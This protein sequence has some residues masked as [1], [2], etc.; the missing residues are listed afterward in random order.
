M[1]KSDPSMAV[2]RE[3]A[4]RPDDEKFLTITS[5]KEK[6]KADRAN[7]VQGLVGTHDLK[8]LPKG[9]EIVLKA[10][11]TEMVLNNWAASQLAALSGIPLAMAARQPAALAAQNFAWGLQARE[12]DKVQLLLTKQAKRAHAPW[13]ARAMTGPTYGRIWDDEVLEAMEEQFGD[14]VTGIWR[15][16]GIRGKALKDNTLQTTT[17]FYG[18]KGPFVFLADE[19]NRIEVK[20][21]RDGKPGT[22]ARG[23]YI[24]NSQVGAGKLRIGLYLYDFLC[25]NRIIWGMEQ[26]EEIAI[27]HSSGAPSRWLMEAMP[28]IKSF[29]AASA[30]PVEAQIKAAQTHQLG[31]GDQVMDFLN[32]RFMKSQTINMMAV[33]VEEEGRPVATRWDAVTA[34]T[35]YA[36]SI[37]WQDERFAIERKAGEMLAA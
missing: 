19:A 29:A 28:Q 23:F 12:A 3:W 6:A 25:E 32:R 22:L 20:A 18:Q 10:D 5:A 27:R 17:I 33:H 9:D 35:A 11:D 4:T 15:V 21:R 1:A 7:S 34:A 26:F 36:K 37:P 16:P 13:E 2:H 8:I 14:G 24:T 30:K 31:S